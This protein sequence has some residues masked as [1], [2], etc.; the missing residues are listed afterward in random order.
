ML[1]AAG[2]SP[3]AVKRRAVAVKRRAVNR[4]TKLKTIC[5]K[6]SY[7]PCQY[8]KHAPL[9]YNRILGNL[10][11]HSSNNIRH[12]TLSAV[13]L[14]GSKNVVAKKTYHSASAVFCIPFLSITPGARTEQP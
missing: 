7:F 8:L 9:A 5:T 6:L 4:S 13:S 3:V 11:L 14:N 12:R 10:P 2:R 1:L